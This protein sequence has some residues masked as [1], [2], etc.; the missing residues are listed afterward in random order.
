MPRATDTSVSSSKV[1]YQTRVQHQICY[2]GGLQRKRKVNWAETDN[3]VG[4]LLFHAHS[5]FFW[6]EA[7]AL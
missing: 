5:H 2:L 3:E 1:E 7:I 4:S 6:K